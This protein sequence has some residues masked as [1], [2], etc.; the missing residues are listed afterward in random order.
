[1]QHPYHIGTKNGTELVD[2]I[3]PYAV[4]NTQQVYP[5][6]HVN[7]LLTS[8]EIQVGIRAPGS[9]T[10]FTYGGLLGPD[11]SLSTFIIQKS[12]QILQN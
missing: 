4:I 6:G 9:A 8:G 3:N 12:A 10:V 7:G 11:N 1:M 2:L 5:I